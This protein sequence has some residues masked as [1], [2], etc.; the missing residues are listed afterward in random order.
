[1]AQKKKKKKDKVDIDSLIEATLN[2]ET[3]LRKI[4]PEHEDIFDE[5]S[6]ALEN[7]LGK[8]KGDVTTDEKRMLYRVTADLITYLLHAQ[9]DMG[10]YQEDLLKIKDN[11]ETRLNYVEP[12]IRLGAKL[13]HKP[14]QK[15]KI[16]EKWENGKN[17]AITALKKSQIHGFNPDINS[18]FRSAIDTSYGSF[19]SIRS[20]LTD[21][22]GRGMK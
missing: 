1:M 9:E 5:A 10:Q 6:T 20:Y 21:F 17:A 14:F 8:K 12:F 7:I 19:S 11:Y 13:D 18:A 3:S 15:K 2:P 4:I 22:Y 16:I